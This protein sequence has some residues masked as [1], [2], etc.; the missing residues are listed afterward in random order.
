MRARPLRVPCRVLPSFV[1]LLLVVV[2]V[3]FVIVVAAP[4]QGQAVQRRRVRGE[5][6]AGGVPASAQRQ[7]AHAACA[8]PAEQ[9]RPS[10]Q[11]GSQVC[12]YISLCYVLSIMAAVVDRSTAHW[13][14]TAVRR[15][16]VCRYVCTVELNVQCTTWYIIELNNSRVRASADWG[17]RDL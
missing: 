3:V 14:H 2:V 15:T 17:S 11:E 13:R 16:Y 8:L 6:R 4:V 5:R 10:L 1:D 12:V 7:E 9:R